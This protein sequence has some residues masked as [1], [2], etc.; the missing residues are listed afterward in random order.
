MTGR[1]PAAGRALLIQLITDVTQ[2]HPVYVGFGND[3]TDLSDLDVGLGNEVGR[4]AAEIVQ[5]SS[6][7]FYIRGEYTAS[8]I[9]NWGE[10]GIF[11]A[12][13]GG[14]CAYRG[15]GFYADAVGA[16]DVISNDIDA[17]G[18]TDVARVDLVITIQQGSY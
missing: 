12:A 9:F 15:G 1:I 11:N 8:G 13:S 2:G 10:V 6:G 14:T 17:V 7:V 16:G 3:V 4:V 5:A 18:D